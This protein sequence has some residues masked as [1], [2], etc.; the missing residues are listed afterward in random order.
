MGTTDHYGLNRLGPG[1]N[2]TQDG[3]KFTDADRQLIDRLL[4]LGAEGHRHTGDAAVIPSLADLSLTL[5][6]TAGSLPA[7][8]RIYYKYTLV[9]VNGM[10]SAPSTEVYVDTPAP[11]TEP[12]APSIVPS[13]T[14]GSL[15]PGQYFYVLT[16]YTTV[17]TNESKGLHPAYITVPVGTTTNS[18]MLTLP[19]LPAGA[20]GLNVYRKKP[21]GS[22][23]DYLAST[24]ST[25]Y[26]DTGA[27]AEDCNRTLPVRNTTNSTNSVTAAVGAA[28]PVVPGGYTW[29]LYRSYV[30]GF[31]DNALLH[32]VVEETAEG[33]GIITPIYVDLGLA[34]SAGKPPTTSQVI[35]GPEPVRLTDMAEVQGALPMSA[36]S[37][38]PAVAEFRVN[39]TLSVSTGTVVWVCEF[40]AA[41]IRGV[42]VSL[43]RGY[44]PASQPVIVDVN[45]GRTATPV[46]TSIFTSSADRPR[47]L[48]GQQI[49][50][51]VAPT[52]T[53][54]LLEG[55]VVTIDIDQVGGGATPTDR[56]L[57][58]QLYLWVY[59]FTSTESF[60]P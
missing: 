28:T 55:D 8:T 49:G 19:S 22:R 16:A 3:Y 33:S 38:F 24:T 1:E 23:Y 31:Y 40:P 25:T 21:G 30:T 29:K 43:G 26:T 46:M 35:G 20:T 57:V 41:S 50:V 42:R 45:V 6:A 14:G 59:G 48:V 32:H 52:A 54:E 9:D 18:I 10:E 17:N 11:I 44:A 27:V 53:T 36:V 34:A 58:V 47:V 51:R 2:L 60:T 56:D 39:G 5:D 12:G 15:L 37:A 13:A 7:G 4:Y